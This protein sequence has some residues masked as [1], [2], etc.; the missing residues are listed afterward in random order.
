MR[1]R[2][3]CVLSLLTVLAVAGEPGAKG[4]QVRLVNATR[5][6]ATVN[7]ELYR[8]YLIVAPGKAGKWKGLRLL[9]DT[10]ATPTVLDRQLAQKLGLVEEPAS[11][12]LVNGKMAA[13]R[14]TLPSLEFG[15]MRRDNLPVMV[16]DLSFFQKA[17]PVR[18]DAVIGLDVL[19][20]A[21]EI[22]YLSRKIYFGPLPPMA[23]SLPLRI[24][25]GLPVVDAQLNHVSLHLLI[26][27]GA[28]SLIL[29]EPATLRPASPT[30][31]SDVQ[32]PPNAIGE[33]G[34]KQVWLRT[35]RLGETE[36][37]REPAFVIRAPGDR[38]RDF[39]GM[40]SPAAL[41]I[42]KVAIDL[43]RGLMAFSR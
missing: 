34:N 27:T 33:F 18:I 7:F 5:V 17:L 24:E 11:I 28:S 38:A 35:L 6:K 3:F 10:G 19:G 9:I 29:F 22:D 23:N 42:T 15:P 31:I 43:E 8:D 30:K 40:M 36:F 41:G 32:Q 1:G 4:Y 2:K 16:E 25:A 21:F 26:D 20:S 39:D 14:A 12:T 13:G 37:G